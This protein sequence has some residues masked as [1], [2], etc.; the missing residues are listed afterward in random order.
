[1]SLTAAILLL[2][3]AFTHAGWNLLG[4]RQHPTAAFFFLA[5][6]AGLICLLLLLPR[7]WNKIPLIPQS[8][9]IFISISGFSLTVYMTSLAGAYRSGDM[10]IA[11]PLARSLPVIIVTS[12]TI[13]LGKGHELEWWFIGGAI[14]VMSGCIM[15]PMKKF[16]DFS[17]KHYI[18]SCCLLSVLAAV[19]IS[20][21]TMV[22][23]EALGHLGELPGNPFT[24][25]DAALLYLLL[26]A[27][28]ASL[29]TGAYVLCVASERKSLV[30]V[31]RFSK[32]P[33]V[34]TGIGIYL[35]YSLV[36]I[37]MNYVRNVSYVVAFR[38]LSIPIG[39]VLGMVLLK[40]KRYLPKVLGVVTIFV[41]LV[42]AGIG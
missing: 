8:V 6:T 3:S 2:I 15:L 18:N 22:D 1:M 27:A 21:Y 35:T 28:S 31:F 10:S 13:I 17:V 24:P 41:G 30:E 7:F 16:G 19:G 37:S 26:E 9:W 33:A 4:K 25:V 5:N 23:S 14:L 42:L 39:A 34:L 38:Q 11:Y 20:G 32:A 12:V 40:E 36:L 29:W